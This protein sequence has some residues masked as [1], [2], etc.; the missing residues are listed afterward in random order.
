[1]CLCITR[2][3]KTNL[4]NLGE[5]I[6]LGLFAMLIKKTIEMQKERNLGKD[7]AL[8]C[9]FSILCCVYAFVCL[10]ACI[11]VFEYF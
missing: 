1:M 8:G 11:C 4:S 3:A 5:H 7:I 2:D 6:A 9:V 10:C